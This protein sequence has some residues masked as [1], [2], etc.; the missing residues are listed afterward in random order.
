MFFSMLVLIKWFEMAALAY[1]QF[2]GSGYRSK[3][4]SRENESTGK[5]KQEQQQQQ[6]SK[7]KIPGNAKQTQTRQV[8]G[9]V[10]STVII[11]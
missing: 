11:I 3:K 8:Q 1:D 7:S 9:I 5:Q 6:L 10:I 4:Q 2:I